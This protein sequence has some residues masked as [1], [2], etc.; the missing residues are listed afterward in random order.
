MTFDG[1]PAETFPLLTRIGDGDRDAFQAIKK[2]Y[3]RDV[4]APAKAFVDAMTTA[5]Q[6]TVS[7]L[8]VGEARTNGSIAP[9]N[10]DL[11]FNPDAQP[12]KDHLFVKWWEGDDKKTAPTLYIRIREAD[13]GFA[14]G[15]PAVDVGRWREAVAGPD[16]AALTDALAGLEADGRELHVA[17]EALKRTPKPWDDEHPRAALLRHKGFQVRWM[18]STPLDVVTTPAIVDHCVDRLAELTDVHRWL[19]DHLG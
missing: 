3:D 9:I 6:Q 2:D 5:L 1:F 14:S 7:P 19:V 12:Y 17:G 8:I 13:V 16:G 15:M 18:E 4:A 11:R 10:N